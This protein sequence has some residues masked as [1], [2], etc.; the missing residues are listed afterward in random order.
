MTLSRYIALYESYKSTL[1]IS[2]HIAD[3]GIFKGGSSFLFAKL[4]NIFEP[5]SFSQ[6]HGFDWF[7]G[8]Q[9]QKFEKNIIPGEG[10]ESHKRIL[11]L[12][13][14]QNLEN[15]LK[16][17]KIDLTKELEKF[18]KKNNHLQFKLIFMDAGMYK[19]VKKALPILWDRLSIGGHLVLDQFNFDVA[20]GETK[21]VKELLPNS[22]IN[23][24][25]FTWMPTAYIVKT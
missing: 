5:N 7:E 10:K 9:P 15:V 17:H 21:A 1:G 6:V 4:I 16:I 24:H 19:V 12:V 25:P 8:N 20:P 13:K 23:T 18:F 14:A 11:E 22:K 3:V 2:G